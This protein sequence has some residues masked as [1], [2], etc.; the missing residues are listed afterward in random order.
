MYSGFSSF[1][2]LFCY[3]GNCCSHLTYLHIHLASL[4]LPRIELLYVLYVASLC[5]VIVININIYPFVV[6]AHMIEAGVRRSSVS[7]VLDAQA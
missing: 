6:I 3:Q 4:E 5:I 1:S 7:K 2:F